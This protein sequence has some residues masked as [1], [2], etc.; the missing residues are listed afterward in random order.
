MPFVMALQT[1]RFILVMFI[2]PGLAQVVA[3]RFDKS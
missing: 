1:A 2:G 3:R